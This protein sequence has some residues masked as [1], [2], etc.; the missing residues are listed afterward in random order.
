MS[1]TRSKK[2]ALKKKKKKQC[3]EAALRKERSKCPHCGG[4]SETFRYMKS[5]Y[6]F[7]VDLARELV[8]DGREPV[9]LEPDDVRFSVDT[10]RIYEQHLPH[11]DTKYPGIIAH[12]WYPEPDG[13][14]LHGH[15]L[16]DGHHRA[17]R[18]LQLEKPFFV[19]ILTEQ[20]SR[21]ILIN[22]PDIEQILQENFPQQTPEENHSA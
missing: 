12:I 5:I 13:N 17:A 6:R 11:V 18:C 4:G 15:V 3:K 21:A 16:I 20:E 14:V 2:D 7:D 1:K 10:S 22:G 19:H 9:E 8:L